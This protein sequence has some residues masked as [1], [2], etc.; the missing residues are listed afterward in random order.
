[1]ALQI[2]D[3]AGLKKSGKTTVVVDLVR[4][5]SVKGYKVGTLKKIHI[6][7]FTI[8]QPGKDTYRHKKAGAEFVI[9]VAPEEIAIIQQL[10]Q[11]KT[12][13]EI[14][15]LV[16]KGTEFLICE[17]LNERSD[18][19]I[20]VITLKSPDMLE[21]TLKVRAIG[22]NVIAIAGV[23]ANDFDKCDKYPV[24]DTTTQ[25][26]IENLVGLILQNRKHD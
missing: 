1:M 17:E 15:E 22:N 26:G 13:A 24:I 9:S 11:K 5:L 23:I 4:E 3:I 2:I 8:D 16:P 18:D 19:I 21:E 14:K 25:D 7:D 12:I 20:Y 6:N 10:K